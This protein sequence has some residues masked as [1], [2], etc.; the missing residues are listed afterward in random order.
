MGFTDKVKEHAAL[1][2]AKTQKS[3]EEHQ[4]KVEEIQAAVAADEVLRELGIQILLE[5]TGRGTATTEVTIGEYLELLKE[6][7]AEFG[8]LSAPDVDGEVT[9]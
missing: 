4:A 2:K 1:A 5:R 3:A 8:A 6:Y 9:S 7:E